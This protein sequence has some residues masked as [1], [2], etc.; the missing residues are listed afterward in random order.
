MSEQVVMPDTR[1]VEEHIREWLLNDLKVMDLVGEMVNKD[2]Q[3]R[4]KDLGGMASDVYEECTCMSQ[5]RTIA[6]ILSRVQEWFL[7]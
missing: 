4:F 5:T 3:A 7:G 1:A 2:M 6:L